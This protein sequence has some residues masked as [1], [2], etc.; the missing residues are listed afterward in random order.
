MEL[1]GTITNVT[2]FGAFVDVGVHQDGLVHISQ[3]ADRFV[4]DPH[5]IVSTG[6]IVKVRVIEVDTDR[7]RIA[8]S[9]R[10][11]QVSPANRPQKKPTKHANNSMSAAFKQAAHKK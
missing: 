4:K 5:D 2:N 10:S 7:K 3:L 11:Q 9:M 6:Q 8:L 1:E